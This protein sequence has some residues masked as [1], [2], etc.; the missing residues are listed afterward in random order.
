VSFTGTDDEPKATVNDRIDL[1]P[2]D[3]L[4][5][6]RAVID[7]NGKQFVAVLTKAGLR[8]F[9][10]VGK[11]FLHSVEVQDE[12]FNSAVAIIGFDPSQTAK[13]CLAL[14]VA[15]GAVLGVV[16]GDLYN[17][18]GAPREV[19]A[20]PDRVRGTVVS[21]DLVRIGP[22]T[23]LAVTTIAGS[24]LLVHFVDW[25][26]LAPQVKAE[27][28]TT[29]TLGSVLT[30]AGQVGQNENWTSNTAWRDFSGLAN[31]DQVAAI[32]TSM[33]AADQQLAVAWFDATGTC[34]IAIVGMRH[35]QTTTTT[36]FGVGQTSMKDE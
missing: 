23:K 16:Q 4:R 2:Y 9:S 33:R 21:A 20:L 1:G 13:S 3:N 31:H 12:V 35:Q 25:N 27:H 24:D 32:V 18:F 28:V 15:Q 17:W 26:N 8:W 11:P 6:A 30:D 5:N 10:N 19:K 36:E 22:S 7:A 14:L 29:L 34:R